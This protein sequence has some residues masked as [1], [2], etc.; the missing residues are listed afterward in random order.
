MVVKSSSQLESSHQHPLPNAVEDSANSDPHSDTPPDM[1]HLSAGRARPKR[2]RRSDSPQHPLQL[3]PL[4]CQAGAES[5]VLGT[6]R[7][8][9]GVARDCAENQNI[10]VGAVWAIFS[11][12]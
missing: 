3:A 11:R 9:L 7:S 1:R 10:E 5:G 12:T 6:K 8:L 4:I 2:T